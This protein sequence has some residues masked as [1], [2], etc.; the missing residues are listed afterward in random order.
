MAKV[1][2]L[3]ETHISSIALARLIESTKD[4]EMIEF[5]TIG[6]LDEPMK[7][8][9][10]F[11]CVISPENLDRLKN[12][13]LEA[14]IVGESFK[15]LAETLNNLK[16]PIEEPKSRYINKPRYNFKRR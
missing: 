10:S 1:I 5:G 14:H 3:G 8:N 6:N 7:L 4:V 16:K 9:Q 15:K 13:G 12:F 11:E 2:I